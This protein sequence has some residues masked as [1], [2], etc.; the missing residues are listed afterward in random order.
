MSKRP[1]TNLAGTAAG[2]DSLLELFERAWQAG[3]PRVEDYLPP[4]GDPRRPAALEALLHAD[5]EYRLKAGQAAR[6][7]DYLGRFPDLAAREQLLLGLFEWEY[8]IR[9]RRE[10]A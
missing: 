9:R 10:P 7:E 1:T 5:L 3:E 6:V 8:R 4:E 2:C